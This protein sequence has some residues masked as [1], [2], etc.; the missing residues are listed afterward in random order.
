MRK[1]ANPHNDAQQW[2]LQGDP[3]IRWQVLCDLTSASTKRIKQERRKVASEGWGARLLKMQ[4]AAGTWGRGLYTPKW[5]S[6][7]YTMLLLRDFGL[8]HSHPQAQ[9][10]CALLLDKGLRGDGGINFGKHDESETCITGMV[11]SILS[12]F[13][14]R[15]PSVDTVVEHLLA[16]QMPDGGWNCRRSRG[17]THSSMNTTISA[18]EALHQYEIN[19]RRKLRDVRAAQERAREFLLIHSLFRSHRTGKVIRPEFM[20]LVYPPRW[21]FDIL[22][23]LDYFRAV[24]APRDRRLSDAIEVVRK[25]RRADGLWSIDYQYAGPTHFQLEK[26]GAPSRW[27]TLRA[28]RV[29]KWWEGNF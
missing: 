11:L 9:R 16:E 6:T 1:S 25:A 4:D 12:H 14:Y 3:A 17:A 15:G 5:T 13:R 8:P 23:A 10:A 19:F 26:R 20:R 7:T 24:S 22:R 28:M 18:L 21:H 27:N 2:L 29:L